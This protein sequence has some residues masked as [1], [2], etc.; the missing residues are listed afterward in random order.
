MGAKMRA[1]LY[2]E[3]ADVLRLRWGIGESSH[4]HFMKKAVE[5]CEA[6]DGV[7]TVRLLEVL[8]FNGTIEAGGRSI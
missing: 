7:L 4:T 6:L 2:W 8:P 1:Q 3:H 5:V